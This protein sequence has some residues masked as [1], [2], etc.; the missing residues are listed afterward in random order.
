MA[1]ITAKTI[2]I[3]ISSSRNSS[4]SYIGYS[5]SIAAPVVVQLHSTN[6]V[7][8]LIITLNLPDYIL[9][10]FFCTLKVPLLTSSPFIG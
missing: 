7:Q 2:Y 6:N 3:E 10:I 9:S 8:N 4:Y 5:S 1:L